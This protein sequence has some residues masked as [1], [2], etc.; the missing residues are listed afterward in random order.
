MWTLLQSFQTQS[1]FFASGFPEMRVLSCLSHS[2]FED[3]W[4]SVKC[5][6]SEKF[7]ELD[8]SK[9]LFGDK[10]L[11][12]FSYS[13]RFPSHGCHYLHVLIPKWTDNDFISVQCRQHNTFIHKLFYFKMEMKHSFLS[14]LVALPYFCHMP[15]LGEARGLRMT[16]VQS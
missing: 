16:T 7:E 6:H 3:R 13:I 8:Q 12:L 1:L 5:R 10:W 15:H 4:K 9:A 14:F 11:C 2:Y